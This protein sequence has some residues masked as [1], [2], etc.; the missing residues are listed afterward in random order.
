VAAS[1]TPAPGDAVQ[2][3][4]DVFVS[5]HQLWPSECHQTFCS[6]KNTTEHLETKHLKSLSAKADKHHFGTFAFYC[7]Q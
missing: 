6:L 5:S 7:Q 1:G 2:L 3:C 4:C